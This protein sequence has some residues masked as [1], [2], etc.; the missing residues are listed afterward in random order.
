MLE[1]KIF[2]FTGSLKIYRLMLHVGGQICHDVTVHCFSLNEM[3]TVLF[4]M[5]VRC[6]HHVL[7][8]ENNNVKLESTHSDRQ[9]KC[10]CTLVTKVCLLLF[11]LLAKCNQFQY[12]KLA[13]VHLFQGASLGNTLPVDAHPAS[14]LRSLTCLVNLSCDHHCD[15]DHCMSPLFYSMISL[16]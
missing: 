9:I 7:L 3:L 2:I 8:R 1:A 10:I 16:T 11:C 4:M 5:W 13:R 14:S 6:Q 12:T 15:H